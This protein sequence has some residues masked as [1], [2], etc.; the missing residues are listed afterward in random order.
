MGKKK[1]NKKAANPLELIEAVK[2][3]DLDK[4][5]QLLDAGADVNVRDGTALEF[6]PLLWAAMTYEAEP[7][8]ELLLERGADVNVHAKHE[9]VTPL[10]WATQHG[11]TGNVRLLLQKN[12]DLDARNVPAKP[13]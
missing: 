4:A 7:M 3:N 13:C 2:D 12:P 9:G 6:T 1:F 11:R 8:V 5:R 10:M